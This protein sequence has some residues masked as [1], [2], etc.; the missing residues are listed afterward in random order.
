MSEKQKP[1]ETIRD[2]E[3]K[4]AIW[5]NEGKNG[6]FYRTSAPTKS[7]KEGEDFKETTGMDGHDQLRLAWLHTEAH[8]KI[9]ELEVAD[10]MARKADGGPSNERQPQ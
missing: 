8:R 7:Y 2:K 5:K 6:T 3:L 4:I 10:R 1:V 9:V